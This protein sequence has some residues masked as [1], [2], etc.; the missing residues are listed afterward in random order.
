M[1]YGI[2]IWRI[3]EVGKKVDV[4]LLEE[5]HNTASLMD[6]GIVLLK[7]RISNG[8]VNFVDDGKKV[9]VQHPKVDI[10]IDAL[11]KMSY[12]WSPGFSVEATCQTEVQ[13]RE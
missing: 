8:I 13:L 4:A 9:S 12:Q 11:F 7:H 5:P 6:R 10:G 1:L 2:E 3:R